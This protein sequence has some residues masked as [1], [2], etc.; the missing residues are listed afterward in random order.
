MGNTLNQI[1]NQFD[2]S[3]NW[4]AY[5]YIIQKVITATLTF[6]FYNNLSA[7]DFSI[8]ANSNSIIFLI[9]LWTD[10]GF[11]KSIP[12][13]IPQF[14]K[15]RKT[16]IIF[17]KSLIKFQFITSIFVT[18]L[19]AVYLQNIAKLLTID[20]SEQIFISIIT[21]FFIE[22]YIAFLRL[23]YHA[24][25]W[26][27]YFNSF[28]SIITI[29]EAI[30][31]SFFIFYLKS[32]SLLTI[33]T[34]KIISGLLIVFFMSIYLVK[35]YLDK[36][37]QA[38]VDKLG[39]NE[40]INNKCFLKHSIAMWF[41][42]VLRSL[43]ERNF[44]I[45]LLTI[46]FGKEFS[47]IFKVSNDW[48]LLFQRAIL[49]SIGTTDTSLFSHVNIIEKS[50]MQNALNKIL[51]KIS[52]ICIPLFGVFIFFVINKNYFIGNDNTIFQTF[53]LLVFLYIIES[54]L[55][56]F[57]RLLEV[58]KRYLILILSYLPYL[59]FFFLIALKKYLPLIGF[60]TFIFVLY[61]VKIANLS[62]IVIYSKRKYKIKIDHLINI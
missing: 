23:L 57:E 20:L 48:A 13:Y 5:H 38:Q 49:K 36:E 33:F 46:Y 29:L 42:S 3:V 2:K 25:F 1:Y 12:K 54:F 10:F 30:A 41:N 39:K 55:L 14:S 45:P 43:G 28:Y 24:H 26:N 6:V 51:S 11:K 61:L 4:N 59:F 32:F 27:Q 8:W 37:Y 19:L 60:W 21:I 31:Y 22:T 15:K 47:N 17:T 35:L 9:L 62:I 18:L 53:L 52:Q 58:N 7:S 44:I 34:V 40:T 50:H 16:H 56:P